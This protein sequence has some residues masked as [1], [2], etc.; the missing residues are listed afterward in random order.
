MAIVQETWYKGT[1]YDP[2]T[3]VTVSLGADNQEGSWPLTPV[4]GSGGT[5]WYISFPYSTYTVYR[6]AKTSTARNGTQFYW[7]DTGD[8]NPR[9]AGQSTVSVYYKDTGTRTVTV[10]CG[11][12]GRLSS[13]SIGS[14]SEAVSMAVL[15]FT[16]RAAHPSCYTCVAAPPP[17]SGTLLSRGLGTPT[18]RG[19]TWNNQIQSGSAP[20][21]LS[22]SISLIAGT[23]DAV[24]TANWT[25]V[26]NPASVWSPKLGNMVIHVLDGNLSETH[27]STSYTASGTKW[28]EF[29]AIAK[30]TA[31]SCSAG[32]KT[33][34]WQSKSQ[35][36]DTAYLL[37]V[38]AATFS[39]TPGTGMRVYGWKLEPAP[40]DG[41]AQAMVDFGS[42]TSALISGFEEGCKVH[43][44]LTSASPNPRVVY[45]G[46]DDTGDV[47]ANEAVVATGTGFTATSATQ[48]AS[49]SA[50]PV[51]ITLSPVAWAKRGLGQARS[52]II[53]S[54]SPIP[55]VNVDGTSASILSSTA[56]FSV[57]HVKFKQTQLDT[58]GLLTI[59]IVED[60]ITPVD[61]ISVRVSQENTPLG[62]LTASGTVGYYVGSGNL[63]VMVDVDYGSQS[64]S[65]FVVNVEVPVSESYEGDVNSGGDVQLAAAV[66]ARS[67]TVNVLQKINYGAI[68]SASM[69]ISRTVGV[70]ELIPN[71]IS[72]D[73][74]IV[75]CYAGQFSVT[76]N[77]ATEIN[78]PIT[79]ECYAK[80]GYRVKTLLVYS[81]DEDVSPQQTYR[82][83]PAKEGV[84]QIESLAIPSIYDGT[85]I[86]FV[87][88]MEANIVG[89]PLIL[90][91]VPDDLGKFSASVVSDG[92]YGDFRVGDSVTLTVDVVEVNST[93]LTGAAIGSP[94][95]ND[96]AVIPVRNGTSVEVT[97]TLGPGT[98]V[99]KIPVYAVLETT[100][101]PAEAG[102]ISLSTVWNVEDTLVIGDVTYRRIGSVF[103]VTAPLA[104]TDPATY[105]LIAGRVSRRAIASGFGYVEVGAL[106]PVVAGATTRT[107]TSTL[108][109]PSEF[110]AV[111]AIGVQYPAFVVAAYDYGAG[112]YITQG[113][114]PAVATT[115]VSPAALS[116]NLIADLVTDWPES[117]TPG[118]DYRDAA[119]LY[120]EVTT[121]DL[122]PGI[123]IR[124][125]SAVGARLEMWNSATSLWVPYSP[126]GITL[127]DAFTYF[128]VSIGDAPENLVSVAFE[129]AVRVDADGNETGVPGCK[130]YAASGTV[131]DGVILLPSTIQARSRTVLHARATSPGYIVT[132]W[133]IDGVLSPHGASLS[134]VVPDIG[135]TL[136]PQVEI[137]QVAPLNVMVLNAD[138]NLTDDGLWVSKLFRAQYPWK[139]LTANV[140]VRPSDAPVTLGVLKDGGDAP[141]ELDTESPGT[142]AITV[143]GDGMRR[144]PPGQIQKTRFVRYMVL[145]SGV[146]SVASVAIGS[147]AE[148][149][150]GGH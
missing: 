145:V 60:T 79:V 150:K 115:P 84:W 137:R 127:A 117:G 88:V 91:M 147:G 129:T 33:R 15:S 125:T 59:T 38:D 36:D 52:V 22:I 108:R 99:F 86:K 118:T 45:D 130:V 76:R 44:Y 5:S 58:D 104:S 25:K 140:V 12:Y 98:N 77:A 122:L 116:D 103:T 135:L 81:D 7:N 48:W 100:T 120:R 71:A 13:P 49:N 96:V 97:V 73:S 28:S 67:I 109:G 92:G 2:D 57:T 9:L 18:F 87:L 124:I 64:K 105:T 20:S 26:D 119:F 83:L 4:G 66:A 82:S 46:F 101:A 6:Y 43:L 34:N 50:A 144:L 17:N 54:G 24:V 149:M 78:E 41:V 63:V 110:T 35:Y 21:E 132:G 29:L 37:N 80:P 123:D 85:D 89:T 106:L 11:Q 95:F 65:D 75:D 23:D 40:I 27:L 69:N 19:W 72:T 146:A 121:T 148:T 53:D 94:T 1:Y 133:Y 32:G 136:K 134:V 142:V 47:P 56:Q 102:T 68:T 114:R 74:L 90:P 138:P 141:E 42:N 139:P 93:P 143:T 30:F 31:L 61:G 111:Y 14:D 39:V 8:G 126:T 62:T 3:N 10:T 112:A 113:V 16:D 128:R 107:F 55:L 131:Y 51:E 70:G